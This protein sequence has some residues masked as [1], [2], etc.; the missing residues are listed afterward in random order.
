VSDAPINWVKHF[1]GPTPADFNYVRESWLM[2]FRKSPW[3]GI[4]PN[5]AYETVMSDAVNQLLHRGAK[6]LMIRNPANPELVIGWTCFELTA[7]GEVVIHFIFVKPTY[8]RNGAASAMLRVILGH[9]RQERFF[10]TC[11]TGQAKF[12]KNG[13]H[14]PEI[15]R[16]KNTKAVDE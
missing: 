2:A 5:N 16:R 4:I 9:A 15:A 1:S 6:L 11:K 13:T 10:Y 12:F 7:R 3:A 8:R 14:R